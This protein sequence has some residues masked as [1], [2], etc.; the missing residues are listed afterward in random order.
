METHEYNGHSI[1]NA[2]E[3]SN[4]FV[5]RLTGLSIGARG[6]EVALI[7][8]LGFVI[9]AVILGTIWLLKDLEDN[10]PLFWA[11][12]MEG[13]I[14]YQLTNVVGA[15]LGVTFVDS[16]NEKSESESPTTD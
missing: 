10:R 11:L 9:V 2:N 14:L 8:T 16:E 4:S 5:A 1:Q 12:V 15:V 6:R 7:A 3:E 13:I